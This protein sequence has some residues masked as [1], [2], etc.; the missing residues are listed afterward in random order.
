MNILAFDLGGSGG[1]M[2]LFTCTDS[3][4]EIKTIHQ[5]EHHPIEVNEGLYWDILYIW[6]NIQTGIKKAIDITGDQIDSFGMD[7]FCND[8]ACMSAAGELLTPVRCY[9]DKRTQ[10]YGQSIYESFSKDVLY[11]ITGNQSAPFTCFMQMS[12]MINAG[13]GYIL[14]NA[15]K[16]LF[17]PDI[18]I[19][20]LTGRWIT[21][22]TMASVSQLYSYDTQ[23]WSP[24][25]LRHLKLTPDKFGIITP[26]GIIIGS[27]KGALNQLWHTRGFPVTTVCSHDTA[28]AF[29]SAGADESTLIIS[30]GTW[31]IAGIEAAGPLI[32]KTGYHYNIANEGS[33][34]GHHRI[35]KNVM[36][37]WILQQIRSEL[38]TGNQFFSYADLEQL[39]AGAT[40]LQWFIDVD[41]LKFYEP[42]HM[43]HKVKDDC[44][45]RYGAA[46]ETLGEIIRCVCESLAFKY[47]M[48]IEALEAATGIT[49]K[50]IHI[51]GGGSKSSLQNQLTAN[52]CGLPVFAGPS[53]ATGYGNIM[54]QLAA[55]GA[56][57]TI[58]EAQSI[59]NRTY[60]K[61]TYSPDRD[62]RWK[63]AY[64][65]FKNIV[66]S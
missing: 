39:A 64:I 35:L 57:G 46:P 1:R 44:L 41:D 29:L 56:A 59:L 52:I 8:F 54:V 62:G 17:V 23:D 43:I 55:I 33:I 20:L 51:V 58:G 7:S 18:F 28:S 61:E 22:Y 31:A 63:S 24:K 27:T 4:V 65:K 49:V 5:F 19:N 42:G 6:Q 21:E 40:E 48:A 53:D 9:R 10:I 15:F 12:A 16:I 26:P 13:Q 45:T 47:R 25:I 50:K 32:C 60:T 11:Q 36:G 34:D 30:S 2:L 3:T 37:T 14:R 66:S 38:N